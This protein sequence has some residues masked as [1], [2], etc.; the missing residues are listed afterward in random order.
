MPVVKLYSKQNGS[1]VFLL[2]SNT[3]NST[4]IIQ[5][6]WDSFEEIKSEV[7]GFTLVYRYNSKLPK[8]RLIDLAKGLQAIRPAFK[9]T[10]TEGKVDDSL[11]IDSVSRAADLS[12]KWR[13]NLDGVGEL[14]IDLIVKQQEKV[15]VELGKLNELLHSHKGSN[16]S[17]PYFGHLYFSN[18]SAANNPDKAD[19]ET[20]ESDS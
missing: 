8:S 18:P 10:G 6:L 4:L 14:S 3:S 20:P 17:K 16:N 11:Q 1:D 12:E 15:Q 7:K 9:F 13:K 5:Q 2:E 19:P